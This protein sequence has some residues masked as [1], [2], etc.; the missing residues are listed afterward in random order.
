MKFEHCRGKTGRRRAKGERVEAG[1]NGRE[2]SSGVGSQ[3]P[4]SLLLLQEREPHVFQA[5]KRLDRDVGK[6]KERM[7]VCVCKC[8]VLS[9]TIAGWASCVGSACNELCSEAYRSFSASREA[10]AASTFLSA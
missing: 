4:F 1:N 2:V 9:L 7:C 6:E 3:G 10:I 5:G 8:C